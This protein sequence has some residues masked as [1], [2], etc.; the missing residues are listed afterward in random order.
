MANFALRGADNIRCRVA[1]I[2][3]MGIICSPV[4]SRCVIESQRGIYV[5]EVKHNNKIII[6]KILQSLH[7]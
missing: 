2:K 3:L 6:I 1:A 5:W 4:K 7:Q